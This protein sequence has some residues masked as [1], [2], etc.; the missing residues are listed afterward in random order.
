MKRITSISLWCRL[1]CRALVPWM[2]IACM[3]N[4][5]SPLFPSAVANDKA[6]VNTNTTIL[7]LGDSIS[8]GYGIPEGKGWVS[9]LQKQLQIQGKSIQVINNSIS[10]DTTAGGLV[11]L[12]RALQDTKPNW[13][14][15]ALG[16]NDGLRGQSLQAMEANLTQIISLSRKL[17]AKPFLL[18]IKLPP[19]YGKQYTQQFEQVFEKISVSTNTPLLPFFLEGVGG[20]TEFMQD[21]RIHPNTKAQSIIHNNVWQFIAPLI[22]Y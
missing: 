14:L 7:I 15:I 11:R 22:N 1:R 21:D 4:L 16:G 5:A 13:V 3:L 17:G 9:L 18:G 12:P 10:G 19:N 6:D 20:K 8:A 2:L